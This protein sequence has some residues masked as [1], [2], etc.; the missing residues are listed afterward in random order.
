MIKKDLLEKVAF[1]HGLPGDERT[2]YV[3]D[4]CSRQRA[5]CA[6]AL[7]WDGLV[8]LEGH[9][10]QG[11]GRWGQV[12]SSQGKVRGLWGKARPLQAQERGACSAP[13]FTSIFSAAVLTIAWRGGDPERGVRRP[14][15]QP[16]EGPGWFEPGGGNFSHLMSPL[17]YKAGVL[18]SPFSD[19]EAE[20]SAR[21]ASLW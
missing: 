21:G 4:E 11:E 6:K 13:A 18:L 10:R 8:W 19:D 2:S 14:L 5:S 17:P 1:G 9:E 7:R 3:G 15:H 12:G 16:G 20:A